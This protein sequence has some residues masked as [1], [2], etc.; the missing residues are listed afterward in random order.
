MT[1]KELREQ[2]E[3]FPDNLIVFIPDDSGRMGFSPLLHIAQG[4]NE[5]DGCLF[6]DFC[7]D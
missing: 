5:A 6:L 1:V 3:G 7:E 2:L 4:V